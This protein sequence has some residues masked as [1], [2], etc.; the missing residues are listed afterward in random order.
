MRQKIC[1]IAEGCYPYIVGGVSSWINALIRGNPDKDYIVFS[2]MPTSREKLEIAYEYPENLIEV[3]TVYLNDLPR[4]SIGDKLKKLEFTK[5]EEELLKRFSKLKR[6][7]DYIDIIKLIGDKEKVPAFEFVSSPFFWDLLI[8]YYNED[9]S[10]VELNKFYW[11]YRAVF[12]FILNTIQNELPEA[13]IYHSV[14]TGYAGFIAT[15]AKVLFNK[16]AIISEH[17]IYARER[18]E[19]IIR[20]K[21][22]DSSLKNIWI[23]F[24][25]YISIVA[26]KSC[27]IT[28]SLF[29]YAH[30]LQLDLG[31]P[32]ERALIIPNGVNVEKLSQIKKVENKKFILGSVL[33]VAPI[34]DVKMMLKAFKIFCEM[35][36][37]VETELLLLGPVDEDKK[38]YKECIELT[39]LLEI[40]K[41]VT[42][43]GR[44]DIREYLGKLDVFLLSSISE[45]QPLSLL[46]AM[47]VKMP[48]IATDVGNCKEILL[49]KE[50]GHAGIIVPPTA[51]TKLALA[52]DHLYKNRAIRE[53][54]AETGY[55]IVNKYY[56]ADQFLE[57]Y[58]KLYESMR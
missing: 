41:L 24:F 49:E 20:A 7:D 12:L 13:D 29:D 9:Y 8:E 47:C 30:H 54:Y 15:A 27:D 18:E 58:R 48:I 38:Y 45:G 51:Y 34:K 10:N 22:L 31:V 11:N 6:E 4:K 40:D 57:N 17:G 33:R 21:W 14:S 16:K 3:R 43:T 52:I 46:E 56:R 23:E 50:E 5:E 53:K 36:K 39:K 1:L 37:E 32:P 26:Y 28:T 2:I 35:N 19:D 42:F 44:V 55:K 25:Y